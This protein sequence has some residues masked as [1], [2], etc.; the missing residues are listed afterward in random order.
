MALPTAE[1]VLDLLKNGTL[2][3][4]SAFLTQLPPTELLDAAAYLVRSSNPAFVV[5]ALGPA[6]LK[7]CYGLHPEWG[8]ILASALD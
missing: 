4:R 6:T 7:Y 1:Q 8:A 2:D 5:V 3:E